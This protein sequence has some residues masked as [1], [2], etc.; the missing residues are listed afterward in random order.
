MASGLIGV[1]MDTVLLLV[2][3]VLK[4]VVENATTH[5]PLEKAQLVL[6]NLRRTEIVKRCHV[7]VSKRL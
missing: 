3:V 6:E 2:E 4:L 7:L 1:D 5:L